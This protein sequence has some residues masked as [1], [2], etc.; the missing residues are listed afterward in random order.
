MDYKTRWAEMKRLHFL[1][2]QDNNKT[3]E[4][5]N[6]HINISFSP[7]YLQ[8]FWQTQTDWAMSFSVFCCSGSPH[9]LFTNIHKTIH[10]LYTEVTNM[11]WL[12]YMDEWTA[13]RESDMK[14]FPSI[15]G[16]WVS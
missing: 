5:H 16:L 2:N 1:F 3:F 11:A 12:Q 9:N 7:Y 15:A 10:S 13:L 8:W 14:L 6:L 4:V